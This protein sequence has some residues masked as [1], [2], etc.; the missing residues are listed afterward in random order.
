MVTLRLG[1]DQRE[2]EIT[3]AEY[4]TVLRIVG[5]AIQGA[6]YMLRKTVS[7]KIPGDSMTSLSR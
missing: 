6:G 4:S 5:K 3:T 7:A 2:D 1:L